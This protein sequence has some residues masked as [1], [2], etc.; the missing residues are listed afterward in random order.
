MLGDQLSDTSQKRL[1]LRSERFPG[2]AVDIDFGDKAP[3]QEDRH[4]NFRLRFD[5][6]TEI[7]PG[8][9]DIGN[10]ECLQTFRALTADTSTIRN[11]GMFS[12]FSAEGTQYKNPLIR[13]CEVEARPVVVRDLLT[14]QITDKLQT[15]TRFFRR[16]Q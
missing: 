15:L 10:D 8:D 12:R 2:V 16:R 1:V 5:A 11:L 7:V 6:A 14:E 13:N 3:I 9:R 4:Y